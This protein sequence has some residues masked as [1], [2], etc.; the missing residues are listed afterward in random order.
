VTVF[1]RTETLLVEAKA[2]VLQITI[3]RP[4]ALNALNHQVLTE[5]TAVFSA[6]AAA[7]EVRAIVLQG[8]GEKAFVAGA[9][10]KQMS[11]MTPA[12]SLEFAR[13]GQGLTMLMA[14]LPQPIIA[15]VQGFALGSGCELAMACDLVVASTRAKFGQ[16]E[17][18][19]GLIAGF[20]GTQRLVRRVGLTLGLDILCA[21]RNLSGEEA[22][23]AGLVAR[24]VPPEELDGEVNKVLKGILRA[25]PHAVAESKRLARQ[26][27]D[28]TLAAGLSAEATAFAACFSGAEAREGM[29]AFVEKRS[30]SFAT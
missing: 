12:Q 22:A 20:G 6:A 17:V 11:A 3:N 24:V 26:A 19:L 25:A 21:G 30:A 4:D 23:A 13:L 2:A 5:L 1:P 15:K 8:A 16:P 14:A 10:V 7:L 18:G 28:M 29:Q 27:Y 9:D